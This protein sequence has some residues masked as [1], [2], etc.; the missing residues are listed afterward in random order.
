MS[1]GL[2]ISLVPEDTSAAAVYGGVY[3]ASVGYLS[4]GLALA[5]LAVGLDT[6]VG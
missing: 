1:T 3:L 4:A 6:F 5:V 2:D